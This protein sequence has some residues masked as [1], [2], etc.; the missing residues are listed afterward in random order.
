M[1]HP[2][3]VFLNRPQ[4]VLKGR[5]RSERHVGHDGERALVRL[6]DEPRPARSSDALKYGFAARA[7]EGIALKA[8]RLIVGRDASIADFH[9][10]LCNGVLQK[11]EERISRA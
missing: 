11:V 9:A 6:D 2:V 7:R 4:G 3:Q 1:T 5:E 8:K 10:P